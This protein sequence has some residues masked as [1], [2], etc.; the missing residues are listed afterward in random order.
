[1]TDGYSEARTIDDKIND[2]LSNGGITHGNVYSWMRFSRTIRTS[3]DIID[4]HIE[5][6]RT[7]SKYPTGHGRIGD[8]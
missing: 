3:L 6:I 2:M 5:R 4:D 8:L 7:E 1:M